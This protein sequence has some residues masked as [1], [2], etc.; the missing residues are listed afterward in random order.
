M[1]TRSRLIRSHYEEGTVSTEDNTE[2]NKAL[3]QRFVAEIMN[4]GNTASIADFCVTGALFAGGFAGQI[5]VIRT[6]FPDF[7]WT[8]DEMFADGN[9]VAVRMTARGANTG[10]LVGLPAF[11]HFDQPLPP[12]STVVVVTGIYIFTVSDGKLVSLAYEIDQV[13]LLQQLGW[14]M[15]PPD[16]GA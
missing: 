9:N 6:A 3:V 2:D 11:G 4:A 1:R 16:P 13:G 5:T 7:H 14:T 8:I 15:T 10:P 12:T